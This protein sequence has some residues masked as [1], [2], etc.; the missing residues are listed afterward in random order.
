MSL[1]LVNWNLEW[2]SPRSSRRR[3]ILRRIRGHDPDVVCLTE[4]H[5]GLLADFGYTICSQADY[6]YP[7]KK[8]R[9]KVLLWSRNSWEDVDCLGDESLPPGRFVSG[10]TRTSLGAVTVIGMCIPWFGSRTEARRGPHRKERWED[11]GQYIA[12]LARVLENAPVKRTIVMGDFNQRIGKGST[13]PARLQEALREAIPAHMAIV[14]SELSFDGRR[15]IDHIVLSEDLA[16]ESVGVISNSNGKAKLS[17]HFGVH[18]EVVG[19]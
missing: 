14:T 3:E 8:C 16:A 4:T 18:A 9:R 11:H 7:I 15:S 12:G 17:D 13:A 1:K 10:V 6:G 2:A 5:E 19:Q